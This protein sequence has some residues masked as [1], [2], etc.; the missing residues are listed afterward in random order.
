MTF[1]IIRAQFHATIFQRASDEPLP[2]T[3]YFMIDNQIWWDIA[4][5]TKKARKI[6][7]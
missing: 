4:R 1:E 7:R 3:P 5:T 2:T 6:T